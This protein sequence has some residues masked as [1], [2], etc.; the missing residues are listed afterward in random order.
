MK[1]EKGITLISL[2]VYVSVLLLAI[3]AITLMTNFFIN[4]TNEAQNSS[5]KMAEIS[6]FDL[7]FLNDIKKEGISIYNPTD[8]NTPAT[9]IIL[10]DINGNNIQYIYNNNI[11]YRIEN[12]TEK[13]K[14]NEDINVFEVQKINDKTISIKI[15]INGKEILKQYK[16]GKY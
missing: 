7:V 10:E 2:I 16:L 14:I 5:K 8:Y 15:T 12:G 13:I 1:S 9:S 11:I 4:N 3:S 6:K